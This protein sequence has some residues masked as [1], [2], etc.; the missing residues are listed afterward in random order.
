MWNYLWHRGLVSLAIMLALACSLL[1]APQWVTTRIRATAKDSVV[2]GARAYAVAESWTGRQTATVRTI[3]AGWTPG[4]TAVDSEQLAAA[5]AERDA[6]IAVQRQLE[7][8]VAALHEELRAARAERNQFLA[9]TESV[10]LVKTVAVPARVIG[11][12]R[13]ATR[14]LTDRLIDTGGASGI[15]AGD[16]VAAGSDVSEDAQSRVEMVIDQGVDA[17]LEADLP[18]A[19]GGVLVGRIRDSG[20]LT[21]TVQLVEDPEFRIGA[22]LVRDTADGPVFGAS[23]VFAGGE[24]GCRLDLIPGTAPV[25]VGDR[26][27]TLEQLG[28]ESVS[29][30]IG[31]VTR[32]ELPAGEPHWRIGIAP[33]ERPATARVDV[34]KVELNPQRLAT[35]EDAEP[36]RA[37]GG[38]LK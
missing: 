22:R 37:F 8:R 19:S 4:G 32:A 25:A 38:R 12:D 33:A 34:L 23:G 31:T 24:E 28:G 17:N 14:K 5:I 10:P 16:L 9:S 15:G 20:N 36:G 18:V 11:Q 2:P 27:Y 1:S 7:V 3:L 30:F 21:S 13:T 29:L 26:V 6:A 35:R